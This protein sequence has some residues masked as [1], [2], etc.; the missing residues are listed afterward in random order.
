MPE[1]D[2]PLKLL[3]S[4]FAP[5]F[6][7]WLLHVDNADIRHVQPVN[8]ELPAG[9]VRADTIFR[10]TLADGRVTLLHV[11][12]QGRHSERPVPLRMLDY[13]SRL[14]QQESGFLC[15]AVLYV[16]DGAGANDDGMHHVACHDGDLTLTWHY[17]VIRLWQMPAEELLA[18]G[19]PALLTLIGQTRL[20][21]PERLLPRVVSRIQQMPDEETRKHLFTAL[22]S[23]MRDEE[24]MKMTE[25]LLETIDRD[26]LLDTPFLRRIRQEGRAEVLAE[27]LTALRESVLEALT[28]RFDPPATHY[29]R[30]EAQLGT[31]NNVSRLRDLLRA[32]LRAA[33]LANFEQ[34]LAS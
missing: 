1:T 33:N 2:T 16:G 32:A 9:A 7:A 14:A 22:L 18:L 11:E 19:R 25:Q 31:V 29:Q 30:I 8:I 13:L 24:V 20:E 17:Q 26:P 23:R 34:A 10:V 27:G 21:E 12:F 15:S 4:E 6:A 5:D 3:V 28:V